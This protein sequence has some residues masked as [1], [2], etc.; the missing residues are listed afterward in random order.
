MVCRELPRILSNKKN[1]FDP[2]MFLAQNGLGRTILELKKHQ[3]V[4]TQGDSADIVF[5]LQKGRI[6]LM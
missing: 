4:F 1:G 3:T 5:Y 2:G 6:K